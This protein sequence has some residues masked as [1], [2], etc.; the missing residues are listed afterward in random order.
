MSVESVATLADLKALT[1]R[2]A[3]VIMLGRA[4][5]GDGGGGTFYWVDGDTTPPDDGIFVQCTSG[6]SGIYKRMIDGDINVLW[7]GATGSREGDDTAALI[8]ATNAVRALGNQGGFDNVGLYFPGG[9]TYVASAPVD[10]S[11]ISQIQCNGWLW[12]RGSVNAPCFVVRVPTNQQG[13]N[14][15]FHGL[16]SMTVPYD[17]M[18]YPL[19]QFSGLR[20]GTVRMGYCTYAEVLGDTVNSTYASTAYSEFYLGQTYRLEI[21]DDA[22]GGNAWCNENKFFGGSI[23]QLRIGGPW[24]DITS[25]TN[26]GSG[27]IRVQTRDPHGYVTG[28]M[29]ECAVVNGVPNAD[30]FFLVTR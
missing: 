30:N 13:S 15:Y 22:K 11:N 3:A 25:A 23:G 4:A 2:P 17:Q 9:R 1:T 5:P 6:P 27:L 28:N 18:R 26:N 14:Y 19:I 10:F 24:R 12:F 7:Y 21:R 8:G 29:V 20:G 16:R